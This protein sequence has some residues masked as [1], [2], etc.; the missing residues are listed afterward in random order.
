M[1]FRNYKES[2]FFGKL[3]GGAGGEQGTA[4]LFAILCE[5]GERLCQS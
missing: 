4:G 3:T 2:D 1:G 5:L